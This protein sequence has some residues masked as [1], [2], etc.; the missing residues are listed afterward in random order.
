MQIE[1]S[2]RAQQQW[3]RILVYY[4]EMGG[5]Q[6]AVKLHQKYLDG[7]KLLI[8]EILVGAEEVFEK[9]NV[10]AQ[11]CDALESVGRVLIVIFIAVLSPIL[12]FKRIN[13][14]LTVHKVDITAAERSG[15]VFILSFGIQTHQSLTALTDIG[16]KQLQ[17]KGFAL[18]GVAEDEDI[19]I[20]LVLCSAVK[21]HEDIRAVFI[22][23]DIEAVG[24]RL[25]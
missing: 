6:A 10:L 8:R 17:Q 7:V 18:T 12:W 15:Q 2:K 24:I 5:E 23:P 3:L 13:F 25:A 19:G 11:P 22:A 16:E 1:V 20:G 21:V 14:V 4:N 9:S